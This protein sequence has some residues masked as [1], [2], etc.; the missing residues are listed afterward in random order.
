MGL[1]YMTLAE[2]K[3][4]TRKEL[5]DEKQYLSVLDPIVHKLQIEQCKAKIAKLEL[6]LK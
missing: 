1:H 2:S 6:Y 4:L 5:E 3:E